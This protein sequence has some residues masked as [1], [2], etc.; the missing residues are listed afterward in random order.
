VTAGN[1][2]AIPYPFVGG[3]LDGYRVDY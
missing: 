2:N 1:A 3:L